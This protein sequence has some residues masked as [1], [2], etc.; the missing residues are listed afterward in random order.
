M[1]KLIIS[2]VLYQLKS[3]RGITFIQLELQYRQREKNNYSP[4]PDALTAWI[5]DAITQLVVQNSSTSFSLFSF[6]TMSVIKRAVQHMA[7][8]CCVWVFCKV[9][10]QYRENIKPRHGYYITREEAEQNMITMS[11]YKDK[12]LFS[13]CYIL[14]VFFLF[15]YF[16]IL[17]HCL[18]LKQICL[19]YIKLSKQ[20]D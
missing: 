4:V 2:H 6:S 18:L 14:T 15:S 5:L 3:Q 8:G 16:I 11:F 9:I 17:Y 7:H 20:L 1:R 19:I 12:R 13:F 10:K